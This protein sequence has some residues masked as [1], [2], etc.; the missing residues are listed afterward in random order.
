MQNNCKV[1]LDFIRVFILRSSV[2]NLHSEFMKDL[3]MHCCQLLAVKSKILPMRKLDI[4]NHN[5]TLLTSAA[6]HTLVESDKQ[7]KLTF[8]FAAEVFLVV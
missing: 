3:A 4:S 7:P 2:A 5:L 1:E 6:K 8:K